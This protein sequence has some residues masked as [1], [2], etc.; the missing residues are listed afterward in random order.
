MLIDESSFVLEDKENEQAL[1]F[2][3]RDSLSKARQNKVGGQLWKF[4]M[5]DISIIYCFPAHQ[6]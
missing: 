1:G 6:D 2:C 3:V 4:Y 5:Q